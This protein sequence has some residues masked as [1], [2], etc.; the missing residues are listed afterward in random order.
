MKL[1]RFLLLGALALLTPMCSA[2]PE[3]TTTSVRV[4]ADFESTW[5]LTQLSLHT[6]DHD[7]LRPVDP[8]PLEPG[9]SIVLLVDDTSAGAALDLTLW[10][11]SQGHNVAYGKASVTPVLHR[12]TDV[13]VGL[14]SLPCGAW[15]TAGATACEANGVKTCEP[16]SSD[17]CLGWSAPTPCPQEAPYCSLGQC[18]ATCVDECATGSVRCAG[19]GAVERCGQ[20]DADTCLDWLPEEACPTATT[21]ESG[22]CKAATACTDECTAGATQCSGAG[23]ASC[24]Q[25]DGDACLDW[26]PPAACP[27]GQTCSNGTCSATCQDECSDNVCAGAVWKQCG[28]LDLDPC[29]ELSAG[30]SCALEDACVAGVCDAKGG[31]SSAPLVCSMPPQS[32]CVDGSTLR[33]YQQNGTCTGGTCDYGPKDVACPNCNGRCSASRY[34]I[35]RPKDAL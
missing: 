20:A 13:H 3:E 16:R 25:F 35:A 1:Q 24:G 15:C 4:I 2:P 34:T 31:C 27:Q 28:Q 18:A 7:T 30:T 26:S 5:N 12:N 32:Q 10:G 22:V 19:S 6:K 21:C 14:A 11:L 9:T 23:V 29:K 33:V 8:K 17:T